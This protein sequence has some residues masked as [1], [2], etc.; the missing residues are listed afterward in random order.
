[1]REILWEPVI[2]VH[3]FEH[4]GPLVRWKSQT[5]DA[6][7]TPNHRWVVETKRRRAPRPEMPS[8]PECG[9]TKGKRGPFPHSRAVATHRARKHGVLRASEPAQVR[10][11]I[12]AGQPEFRTTA[13]LAGRYDCIIT[14]GGT[15]ACLAPAPVHTDEFVELIGWVITE[16]HYQS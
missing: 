16:G 1:T 2:S 3:R 15:P 10:A 8:C 5:M 14:G 13:E 7:T 11:A 4:D 6:L 12:F 9:A